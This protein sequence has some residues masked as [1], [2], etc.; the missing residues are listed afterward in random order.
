MSADGK[1]VVHDSGG[2]GRRRRRQ[3]SVASTSLDNS[4]TY[5]GTAPTV[6]INQAVGQG[7]S[8]QL[9]RPSSFTVTF[10]ETV[11]GFTAG[12][13]SFTA[14]RWAG[15]R[16]LHLGDRPVYTV[17]VTGMSARHGR[18]EHSRGR[19]KR[20]RRKP[21]RRLD[22]QRQLGDLRYGVAPT[23]TINQAAGQAGSD[24]RLADPVHVVTSTSP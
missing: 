24:E 19:R 6:T 1:V 16:G 14:R 13:V 9:P 20:C 21:Q 10:S 3:P 5:D 4:V 7:G 23:V 18:R 11:T 15:R 8:D 22:Q 17:S 12:D 2:S